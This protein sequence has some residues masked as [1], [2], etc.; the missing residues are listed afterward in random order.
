[1]P[2]LSRIWLNPLRTGAQRLLTS[3]HA[4]HAAVLGG[5]SEQPVHQRTL[6]RLETD[7]AHR[8]AL[9]VLTQTRPSWE[10]LVE[11]AGWPAADEPQSLVRD[12]QPL[13]DLVQSGR[14]FAFRLRAN[15]VSSTRRPQ[16]PSARQRDH[17]ATERPRGVRVPERTAAQQ[18]EWFARRLPTWGLHPVDIDGLPQLRLS[19]REAVE[20]HKS[21]PGGT[22]RHVRLQ[23]AT[24]E[25]T[26]TVHDPGLTRDT[27][28][29][30]CGRGRAY[31][32]GLLTLA[33]VHSAGG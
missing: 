31:G 7:S 32:C 23:T 21:D 12:Y 20:F 9:L 19:G 13:L 25:G 11:Q 6:W 17:L 14:Q 26:V 18:L 3:P 1:M 16:A 15:T 29:A 8:A 22:R 33:P 2:F 24:A 5:L 10:H 4:T 27:L 30:G 28:L